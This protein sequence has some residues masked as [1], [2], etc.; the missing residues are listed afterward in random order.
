MT[1]QDTNISPA[2]TCP[3]R[4]ALIA[5]ARDC[6]VLLGQLDSDE[7]LRAAAAGDRGQ[8]RKW[9]TEVAGQCRR[10]EEVFDLD[11]TLA[12]EAWLR[13]VDVLVEVAR[14]VRTLTRS[15]LRAPAGQ[16]RFGRD[17]EAVRQ[18]YSDAQAL[19]ERAAV[20]AEQVLG[21]ARPDHDTVEGQQAIS[22]TRLSQN[23]QVFPE[24]VE[25]MRAALVGALKVK[26]PHPHATELAD[27]LDQ[28][29]RHVQAV[30]N[31]DTHQRR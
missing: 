27:L 31:E 29:D 14:Q 4:D 13:E 19:T 26:H 17:G 1:S 15:V 21:R 24:A 18:Q 28:L 7:R 9:L 25:Q 11:P 16:G 12:D 23:I 22:L 6:D 10:A 8:A 2:I 3:A 20:L 5:A 30:Q